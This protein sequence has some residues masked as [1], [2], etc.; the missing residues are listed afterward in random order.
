MIVQAHY[1]LP[2]TFTHQGLDY[3]RAEGNEGILWLGTDA[4]KK[5]IE[6][7]LDYCQKWSKRHGRPIYI[8]EYGVIDDAEAASRARYMGYMKDAFE[9]RGFSSHIWGFREAFGFYNPQT[10][11][12]DENILQALNLK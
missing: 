7:D 9:K 11:T 10:N 12:F 4:D 1:Y 2:H 8:G 5:P 6:A 3:A